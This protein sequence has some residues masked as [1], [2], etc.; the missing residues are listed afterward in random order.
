MSEATRF[1]S[2]LMHQVAMNINTAMPC[3]VLSY[4]KEKRTAKIQPLFMVKEV[5]RE[6]EP[7]PPIDNVP[8]LFHRFEFIDLDDGEKTVT[9]EFVPVLRSGDVVLAVFAQRA[10]DNVMSGRI[11]YPGI[12]RHHDLQDAI[13]V[14]VMF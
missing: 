10:L 5:G 1:F 2:N 9:R 14:G 8:V 13:I 12:N 6:P 4:N 7:L 3:K 11:A